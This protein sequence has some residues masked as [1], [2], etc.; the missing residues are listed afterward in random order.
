MRPTDDPP[1]NWANLSEEELK[2]Y[3]YL[4][5]KLRGMPLPEP[6]PQEIVIGS[7]TRANNTPT[8]QAPALLEQES[9]QADDSVV[10]VVDPPPETMRDKIIR[11]HQSGMP[12]NAICNALALSRS[13][14][15]AVLEDNTGGALQ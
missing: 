8:A 12:P 11:M 5:L 13:A 10:A 2:Q 15:M 9:P 7:Y 1:I 14:L 6:E 3:E 4:N